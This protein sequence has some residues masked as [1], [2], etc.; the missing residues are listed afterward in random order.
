M[1]FQK[2]FDILWKNL[3]YNNFILFRISTNF[4][5]SSCKHLQKLSPS[6]VFSI[7]NSVL[8]FFLIS[9][10]IATDFNVFGDIR[11]GCSKT[12]WSIPE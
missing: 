2:F 3:S 5:H 12:S 9:L 7:L 8:H 10:G 1:F 4:I 11:P 6:Y